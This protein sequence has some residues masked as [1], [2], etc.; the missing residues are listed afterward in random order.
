MILGYTI[1]LKLRYIEGVYV[2]IYPLQFQVSAKYSMWFSRYDLGSLVL[3]LWA[4]LTKSISI[5]EG[6]MEFVE[7]KNQFWGVN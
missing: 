6:H 4:Q 2:R 7:K 3:K 1:K 5:S